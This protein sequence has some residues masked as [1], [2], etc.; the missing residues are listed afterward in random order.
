MRAN[1]AIG[2][3]GIS[4]GDRDYLLRPS[5]RA[6][7]ELD[8]PRGLVELFALV[9]G[10][11]RSHHLL[12]AFNRAETNRHFR[13]CVDVISACS[14][15]D[16]T[17]LTG[18]PGERWGAWRPGAMGRVEIVALAQSLL[19]HGMIGVLPPVP[20]APGAP[21][22]ETS[23]EFNAAE[24]VALAVA[25]LGMSEA[26]AWNLTMTSF[27]M[28]ARAKYPPPKSNAPSEAEHDHV[29]NWLAEIN[30]IRDGA[31]ANGE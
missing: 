13:A 17:P 20:A 5:F 1:T 4:H 8:T 22:P 16:L 28:Y 23:N 27:A 18:Y 31:P 26:D 9:H 15:D 7:S 6:L 2:E 14:D 21:P 12:A 10:G 19:R 11:P 24:Y 29:M 30:A 25:H 3:I